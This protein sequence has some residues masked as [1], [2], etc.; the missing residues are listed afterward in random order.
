MAKKTRKLRPWTKDDVRMLKT[1]GRAKATAALIARKLKRSV[2]AT[3][4]KARAVGVS[5]GVPRKKKR[6]I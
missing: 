4:N 3:Y 6:T 5:V 2:A 1:L